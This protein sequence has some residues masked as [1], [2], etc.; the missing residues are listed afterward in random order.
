MMYAYVRCLEDNVTRSIKVDKIKN[1]DPEDLKMHEKK[2]KVLW[3]EDGE[4][5]PA[6]IIYVRGES[7]SFS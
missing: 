5:Y 2:Y 4:Y 7:N 3:D 1:F 6:S